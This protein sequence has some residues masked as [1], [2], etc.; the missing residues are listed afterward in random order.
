VRHEANQRESKFIRF[1]TFNLGFLEK[2]SGYLGLAD[3]GKSDGE[4]GSE[5]ERYDAAQHQADHPLK[6]QEI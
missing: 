5:N 6:K 4:Q 1:L 2:L 3:S